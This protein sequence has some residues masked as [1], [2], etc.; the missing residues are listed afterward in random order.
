MKTLVYKTFAV[1]LALIFQVSTGG[2]L[3]YIHHC[4]HQQETYTSLFVGFGD[5]EEHPCHHDLPAIPISCCGHETQEPAGACDTSCCHD[6]AMLLRFI[7]DTEPAQTGNVKPA[8]VPLE[9]ACYVNYT[10]SLPVDAETEIV[11][12]IPPEKPPISG[13]ELVILYQQIKID[14]MA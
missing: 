5:G 6:M 12:D 7:P 13:R 4:Q 8:P 9:I 11:F 10:A 14:L 1:V 3:V 2:V